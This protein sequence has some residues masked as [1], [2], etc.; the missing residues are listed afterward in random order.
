MNRSMC[1][2]LLSLTSAAFTAQARAQVNPAFADVEDDI[3]MVR[4]LVR[5]DRRVIVEEAMELLPAER[6]GFWPI[7]DEY[8]AERTKLNDRKVKLI[9]DYAA[10]Y[11]NLTD[12]RA[13]VLLDD[14]FTLEGDALDLRQKYARRF[15]K[16]LTPTRVARF[17]QIENKLDSV[18]NLGL[19]EEIP[20]TE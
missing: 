14:W 15:G 18:I 16:A 9:T 10:A 4:Q 2:I 3:A 1:L 6:Q 19:A 5:A 11:P 8:E 13:E 17:F 20:L 7:Y 12:A